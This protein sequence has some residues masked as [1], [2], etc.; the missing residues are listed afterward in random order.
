MQGRFISLHFLQRRENAVSLHPLNF[1]D[2]HARDARRAIETI[3]HHA[4]R[5][6]PVV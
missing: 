5:A 2:V 6:A 4:R 3:E 1:I